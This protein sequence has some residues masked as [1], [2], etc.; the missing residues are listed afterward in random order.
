VSDER[1]DAV[2]SVLARWDREAGEGRHWRTLADE[3]RDAIDHG[4]TARDGI[5]DGCGGKL[6]RHRKGCLRH[7]RRGGTFDPTGV[8][9]V[10]GGCP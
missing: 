7:L 6:P 2:E 8:P 4:P 1:L 3:V 5:C 10:G 9:L